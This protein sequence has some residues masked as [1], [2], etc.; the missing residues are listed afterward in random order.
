[1]VENLRRHYILTVQRWR[2]N[3]L[4]NYEEIKAAMGYD[5]RFMR[6]WDFYLASG[7]AGFCLGYLNVI[8]MMMTNGVVNDYPW[9]REFLY[10]ETALE[11]VDG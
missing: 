2:A 8:Q 10:E 5:D 7:S 3:F 1:D 4:R 9:T 11:L 6:T